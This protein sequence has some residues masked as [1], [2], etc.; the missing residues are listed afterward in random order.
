MLVLIDESG[1]PGF[2]VVQGSTSH[3]VLAMVL[4]EDLKEAER[5]SRCIGELRDGLRIKPEFKFAKAA[6]EVRNRFFAAVSQHRFEVRAIV[7]DKA[8]VQSPHLRCNTDSFY[9]FFLNMLL[10][11]DG[12][13][14]QGASIKIDGSG[15]AEF[16]K[17]LTTYLR[18]Q[19]RDGQIGKF[20][21]VDSKSD[22]LIQ[23]ADMCSG[24]IL[25]A[26]RSDHRR[27]DSWLTV[28]RRAGRI[29]DIWPFR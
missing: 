28:L 19:L 27:D 9:N 2:R 6:D 23:L 7:V 10:K 29:R 8:N 13:A 22:N 4:F 25:R 20:K 18:R 26:H 12:G 17:E 21:F 15:D 3:F 1:D 5:C 24:A 14:T 16:K 11:H